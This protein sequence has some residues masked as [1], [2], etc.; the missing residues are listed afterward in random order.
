MA[1]MGV[2]LIEG[3]V[4]SVVK[5]SLHSP[6]TARSQM[7]ALGGILIGTSCSVAL[8]ID[9]E[10]ARNEMRLNFT[11]PNLV[12]VVTI[13][14]FRPRGWEEWP[15]CRIHVSSDGNTTAVD[16]AAARAPNA[17]TIRSAPTLFMQDCG[18]IDAAVLRLRNHNLKMA[19]HGNP[20]QLLGDQ[21]P[22]GLVF[23]RGYTLIQVSGSVSGKGGEYGRCLRA[24]GSRGTERGTG[25]GGLWGAVRPWRCC[26]RRSQGSE[27]IHAKSRSFVVYQGR[28]F[29]LRG[30]M[31]TV[32]QSG[33]RLIQSIRRRG[34]LI[35][36][37]PLSPFTPSAPTRKA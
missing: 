26:S 36:F 4:R 21:L 31:R 7:V 14:S 35:G 13:C 29:Q 25:R 5:A 34:F 23:Q 16:C 28:C 1:P 33:N 12:P 20:L 3:A 10:V 18:R 19:S 27:K 30:L 24:Y 11:S 15:P 6:L 37:E 32:C 22:R 17:T 8:L 9:V 2:M